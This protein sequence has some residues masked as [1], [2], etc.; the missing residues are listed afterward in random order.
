MRV[1]RASHDFCE[2][3]RRRSGKTFLL[4]AL[5]SP[6][7]RVRGLRVGPGGDSFRCSVEG[8]GRGCPAGRDLVHFLV[9]E[10]NEAR[11]CASLATSAHPRSVGER[12]GGRPWPLLRVHSA[13]A[14]QG[15]ELH[16][17]LCHVLGPLMAPCGVRCSG[18][19]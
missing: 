11:C 4:L 5:S 8:A 18:V 14:L 17:A 2:V 3:P 9:L 13:S 15:P 19:Q 16:S 7:G 10:E 12:H 6:T 1:S